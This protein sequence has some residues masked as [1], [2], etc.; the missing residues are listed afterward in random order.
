MDAVAFGLICA[1]MW[2]YGSLAASR[3]VRIIGQASV[4]A[5][6]M[7]VGF[8]VWLP[9]VLAS[10]PP[11]DFTPVDYLWLAASGVGNVLG[12][13]ATYAAYRIGK[14]G[15]VAAVASTEGAI[16]ALI[17]VAAGE[18]IA[19]QSAVLLAV[20]VASV[21]VVAAT[22]D[23]TPIEAVHPSRAALLAG[24][25]AALF[26][27]SLYATS[28][29]GRSVSLA[30]A[31]LPPRALGVVVLAIPLVV[32]GRLQSDRRAM[33]LVISTGLSEVLGACA[34]V[35]GTRSNIAVTSVLA[36]QFPVMSAVAAF[37]LF[38]ERLTR[39]HLAAVVVLVGATATLA[40]VSAS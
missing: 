18:R 23:P 12:L 40:V 17:A 38:R 13:M 25:S 36:A 7:L 21:V 5:W 1:A 27:V 24:L 6:V 33:P 15:V 22:R 31:V 19:P 35:Y 8:L 10:G 3:A 26:G 30:W 9:V 16:V 14:V 11:P 34:Y 32:R 20:I 2:S 4:V 28:Q 39:T 37:V 29:L